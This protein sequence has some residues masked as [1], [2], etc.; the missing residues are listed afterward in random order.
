MQKL[1]LVAAVMLALAA[2]GPADQ[3]KTADQSTPVQSG[4]DVTPD[5]A[6]WERMAGSVTLA[7]TRTPEAG[8]TIAFGAG[9]GQA[10]TVFWDVPVAVGQ[11]S[12]VRFRAWSDAPRRTRFVLIRHC[13]DGEDFLES[14]ADL[15]TTPQDIEIQHTWRVAFE[16]TRVDV[17]SE[18]AGI[19]SV[20]PARL[21]Q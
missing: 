7:P 21:T 6:A 1:V 10:A 20:T 18:R 5:G 16:C 14:F 4:Q 2:C 13:G 19:V 3:S 15:T 17:Y 11:V 8:T 12:T 9:G